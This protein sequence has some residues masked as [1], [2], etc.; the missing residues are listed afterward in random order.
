MSDM[1]DLSLSM[2]WIDGRKAIDSTG[3][4]WLEK[5][6]HLHRFPTRVVAATREGFEIS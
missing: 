6:I 2:A 3:H 4:S 1:S 5:V